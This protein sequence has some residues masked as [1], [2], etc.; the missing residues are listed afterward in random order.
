MSFTRFQMLVF[1]ACSQIP[2]G[3]VSTYAEIAKAVGNPNAARAVG[4]ALN[5]NPYDGV[6]CHRVVNSNGSLGGFA[7]GPE[8]KALKL[9]K[10]RVA[11]EKGRVKDFTAKF[12]RLR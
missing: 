12:H 7:H 4:N 2:R 9:A 10:E 1:A 3:K 5:K 11:V 8:A 6:P